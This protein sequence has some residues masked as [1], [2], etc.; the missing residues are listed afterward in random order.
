MVTAGPTREPVDPVRY[1]SNR[2]SGKM[3]YA[4]A[5]AARDAGADVILLSGPVNLR[6]PVGIEVID[7]ETAE[8]LYRTT[9]ANIDDVDLFI[10]AAAVADYRPAHIAD[11]KIKKSESEMTIN[12]VRN[13]DTL[14]TVSALEKRPFCVGFAAETDEV[15]A[16][17]KNKLENK[18]LDMIVANKVG[19]GVGFDSDDNTVEVFWGS[20]S[21]RFPTETKSSLAIQL[22][23]LIAQRFAVASVGESASTA[24]K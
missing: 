21:K 10:A 18:K 22:V 17:A 7:I 2:S 24:T 11:K 14:A 12:L 4:I 20:G 6:R 16:Y 9:H 13:R 23:R 19:D 15:A 5:E 1:M 3:G 8:D